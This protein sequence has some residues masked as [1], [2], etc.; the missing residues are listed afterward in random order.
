[1]KDLISYKKIN[2]PNLINVVKDK[3]LTK[4]N[5]YND[6]KTYWNL[7]SIGILLLR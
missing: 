2:Q 1:M 6:L 5:D 4:L 3:I 7:Y